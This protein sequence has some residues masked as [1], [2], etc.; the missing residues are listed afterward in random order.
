[1]APGVPWLWGQGGGFCY[2]AFAVKS[3]KTEAPA[4]QTKDPAL[5]SVEEA[6]A[7]MKTL[8][9]LLAQPSAMSPLL[10]FGAGQQDR[11]DHT[12]NV[13]VTCT[14]QNG[15]CGVVEIPLEC[16]L[17][18]LLLFFLECSYDSIELIVDLFFVID[19]LERAP[20]LL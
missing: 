11:R 6:A 14:I 5:I 1:M 3:L 15:E 13:T 18:G 16:L 9:T 10:V 17:G 12:N 2:R 20:S 8:A 19:S 7:A 4:R